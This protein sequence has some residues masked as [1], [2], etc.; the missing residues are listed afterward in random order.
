MASQ[1]FAALLALLTT[2]ALSC[3]GVLGLEQGLIVPSDDEGAGAGGA[4]NASGGS[5]GSGGSITAAGGQGGVGGAADRTIIYVDS[6]GGDE[7]NDGLSEST[8]V[9]TIDQAVA[10]VV[11]HDADEIRVCAGVYDR[12]T[13]NVDVA[14]VGSWACDW[15]AQDINNHTSLIRG[16]DELPG[17]WIEGT[18]SDRLERLEISG[19]VIE[20]GSIGNPGA[21]AVYIVDAQPVVAQNLITATNDATDGTVAVLIDSGADPTIALNEIDGGGPERNEGSGP[22]SVGVFV[23][24]NAA[25]ATIRD[26]FIR[27]GRGN[28]D[29]AG[30]HPLDVDARASLAVRIEGDGSANPPAAVLVQANLLIGGDQANPVGEFAA[31]GVLVRNRADVTIDQNVIFNEAVGDCS[32]VRNAIGPADC[33]MGIIVFD[34]PG[35]AV[36][37][38]NRIHTG[39]APNGDTTGIFL[40]SAHTSTVDNNQVLAGRVLNFSGR[41]RAINLSSADDVRVRHNTIVTSSSTDAWGVNMVGATSTRVENNLFINVGLVD[42]TIYRKN[43]CG[44][45][46]P[47]ARGNVFTTIVRAE[48]VDTNSYNTL[49]EFE[50]VGAEVTDNTLLSNNCVAATNSCVMESSVLNSLSVAFR[51]DRA[52]ARI[53]D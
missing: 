12:A 5:G 15:A 3:A 27:G 33:L 11:P 24:A 30:A 41:A 16:V 28:W 4:T 51:R 14:I 6:I 26:N 52:S 2:A 38:A 32:D 37:T 40:Q 36:I 21:V 45:D 44:S 49:D 13:I 1:R 39:D 7:S 23:T 53:G 31:A 22:A 17:L 42:M 47:I 25:G 10:L 48:C 8:P 35:G 29:G 9:A 34:A 19:F 20:S 18:P 46:A 43:N 50:G